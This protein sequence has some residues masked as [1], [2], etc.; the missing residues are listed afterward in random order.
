LPFSP[1]WFSGA[2][3]HRGQQRLVE[4]PFQDVA[5]FRNERRFRL[6]YQLA[7]HLC[8]KEGNFLGFVSDP[9]ELLQRAMGPDNL[10]ELR[11]DLFETDVS[12]LVSVLKINNAVANVVGRLH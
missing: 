6:P 12:Q 3:R 7:N 9:V 5:L 11:S 8:P 1:S 4:P 10:H 2:L